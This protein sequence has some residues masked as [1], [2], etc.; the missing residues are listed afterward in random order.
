MHGVVHVVYL[1]KEFHSPKT[2]LLIT[3]IKN[4]ESLCTKHIEVGVY[5]L[6]WQRMKYV[7]CDCVTAHVFVSY[8]ETVGEDT[9]FSVLDSSA[10]GDAA[11]AAAAAVTANK[12][13]VSAHTL[14]AHNL[15]T[16]ATD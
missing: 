13:T 12:H 15:T 11:A 2:H 8:P 4:P 9:G 16:A 7:E 14:Q 1:L 6:H 5:A 3:C 10:L